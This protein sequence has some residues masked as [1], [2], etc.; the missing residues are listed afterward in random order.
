MDDTGE[1][2]LVSGERVD[3]HNVDWIPD[4]VMLEI[5]CSRSELMSL[6]GL[7]HG[8]L[9]SAPLAAVSGL[10]VSSPKRWKQS[11]LGKWGA[12]SDALANGVLVNR[13]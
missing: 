10:S 4:E 1:V 9:C 13:S 5:D 6:Q 7:S 2:A 3:S 8:T 12:D 11:S